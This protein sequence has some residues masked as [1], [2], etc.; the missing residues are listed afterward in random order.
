[1]RQPA[2]L[3]PVFAALALAATHSL[4]G[5]IVTDVLT[6]NVADRAITATHSTNFSPVIDG[7]GT[8][9]SASATAAAVGNPGSYSAGNGT[10]SIYVI[11]FQLPTL[12]AVVNPFSSASF[13]LVQTGGINTFANLGID[14]YGLERRGA[15]TV[16]GS[17]YFAGA[18]DSTGATLLQ[19]DFITSNTGSPT[20]SGTTFTF[21]GASLVSYLNASYADGAGAG[22]YVFLRL[23][24][25]RTPNDF[26]KTVSFNTADSTNALLRPQIA[27]T[28]T[29]VPEPAAVGAA[30]GLLMVVA[31]LARR[32]LRRQ[33]S[34]A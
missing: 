4:S 2:Y 18:S 28:A 30:M 13:S 10:F 5:Q 11:P 9:G 22:Q 20:A 34:I 21:S 29:A 16:L 12:G 3:A 15:A 8:V 23:S 17:D 19:N 32:R 31:A 25:D 33:P 14:L 27:F 7:G 26:F 1:M 24:L 6:A